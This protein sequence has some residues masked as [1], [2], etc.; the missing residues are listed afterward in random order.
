MSYSTLK[1]SEDQKYW[2]SV[3]A[4]VSVLLVGLALFIM[5]AEELRAEALREI[6]SMGCFEMRE[7]LA[8]ENI[9]TY[10]YGKAEQRFKWECAD[11]NVLEMET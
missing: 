3:L 9:H 10:E 1:L 6:Q 4:V 2:L 8:T 5:H 7:Y 11:S